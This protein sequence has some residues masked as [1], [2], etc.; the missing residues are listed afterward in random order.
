ME[1]YSVIGGNEVLMLAIT[2]MNFENIMLSEASQSQ[3]DKCYMI[4]YMRSL[5]YA[6]S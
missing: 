3:M 2:W 1:C 6:N 5:K 4:T